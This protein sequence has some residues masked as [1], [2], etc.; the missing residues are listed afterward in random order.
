MLVFAKE[1]KEVAPFLRSVERKERPKLFKL[2]HFRPR[3]TFQRR[4]K[5]ES[6][7][8]AGSAAHRLS[9]L[10]LS[11]AHLDVLKTD[12][13]NNTHDDEKLPAKRNRTNKNE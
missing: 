4:D 2:H 6:F 7:A 11:L 3:R 5:R 1:G 13:Q 9:T 8:A 10:L 12:L